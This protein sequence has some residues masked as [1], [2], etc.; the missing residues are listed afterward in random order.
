MTGQQI[1]WVVQDIWAR[2][3]AKGGTNTAWACEKIEHLRVFFDFSTFERYADLPDTPIKG[4][5]R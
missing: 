4:D 3:G 2:V 5:N 1:R